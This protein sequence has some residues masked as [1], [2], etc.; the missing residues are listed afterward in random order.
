MVVAAAPRVPGGRDGHDGERR[1]VVVGGVARLPPQS[2]AVPDLRERKAGSRQRHDRRQTDDN[3]P[4]HF[5][6]N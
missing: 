2:D 6:L 1:G 3:P 5:A 4:P